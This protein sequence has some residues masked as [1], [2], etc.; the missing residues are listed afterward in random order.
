MFFNIESTTVAPKIHDTVSAAGLFGTHLHGGQEQREWWQSRRLVVE[1]DG[2]PWR[3]FAPSKVD[4]AKISII[5]KW[6]DMAIWLFYLT[7]V[8]M[9]ENEN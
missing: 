2:N 9:A 3:C 1:K 8:D 5:R 4:M 6:H 7:Q